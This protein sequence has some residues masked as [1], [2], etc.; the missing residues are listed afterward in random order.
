VTTRAANASAALHAQATSLAARGQLA[1]AIP[2]WGEAL[3]QDPN[4]VAV[5]V[6][7]GNALAGVGEFMNAHDLAERAAGLAP[8]TSAP[9]LLLGQVSIALAYPERAV[10]ALMLAVQKAT[11]DDVA[12]CKVELA[13]AL[14]SFGRPREAA[15]AVKDVDN[16]DA[17]VIRAHALVESGDPVAAIPVLQRAGELDPDHP[18]PFKRLAV[19]FAEREPTLAREL[20]RYA[21]ELAPNDPEARA[22]VDAL[23]L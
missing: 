5:L 6:A 18:E 2:I 19:L 21:L 7:L 11:G 23:G 1:E 22:L 8:D 13:K 9:W 10:E 14:A 17:L 15:D 4:D 20:A 3:R 16:A 12:R